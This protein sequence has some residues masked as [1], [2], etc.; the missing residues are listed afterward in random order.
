M[1]ITLL[2]G[3]HT[4][5]IINRFTFFSRVRACLVSGDTFKLGLEELDSKLRLQC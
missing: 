4:L 3:T 2:K 1:C 5:S